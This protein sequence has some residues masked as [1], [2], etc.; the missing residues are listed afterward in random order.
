[1]KK[2]DTLIQEVEIGKANVN[3]ESILF[4]LNDYK[5]L[6][7]ELDDCTEDLVQTLWFVHALKEFIKSKGLYGEHKIFV[8]ELMEKEEKKFLKNENNDK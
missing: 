3:I 2:I 4:Y 7:K 5:D 6:E 1:M 8:K